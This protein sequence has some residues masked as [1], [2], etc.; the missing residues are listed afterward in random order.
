MALHAEVPRSSST[1]RSRTRST[2]AAAGPP[3]GIPTLA[4]VKRLGI[5]FPEVVALLEGQRGDG[6]IRVAGKERPWRAGMT[7]ADLLQEIG[8]EPHDCP[9]VRVNDHYVSRPNFADNPDSRTTPRFF[10][11][12]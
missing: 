5:D 7:V 2:S 10:S 6:M 4:T 11:S 3:D 1:K 12:R 9:V 8:D